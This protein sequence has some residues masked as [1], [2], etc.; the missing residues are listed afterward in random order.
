M[1]RCT[2]LSRLLYLLWPAIDAEVI[3]YFC[4]RSWC[5]NR[6]IGLDLASVL[7]SVRIFFE[8]VH[9]KLMDM[10]SEIAE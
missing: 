8:R 10:E 6:C 7:V 5:L 2:E 4:G 3:F 1:W 9:I